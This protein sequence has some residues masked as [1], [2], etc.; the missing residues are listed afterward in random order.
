[1]IMMKINES[2]KHKIFCHKTKNQISRLQNLSRSKSTR[3]RNTVPRKNKFD[4]D[5]TIRENH[6]NFIK[7]L[8]NIK[9]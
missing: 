5:S 3:K 1:M 7:K 2:K 8:I 6:K 4:R 9:D